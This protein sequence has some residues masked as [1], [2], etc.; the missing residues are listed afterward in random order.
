MTHNRVKDFDNHIDD[1]YD[2]LIIGIVRQAVKDLNSK[3]P[4][5]RESAALFFRDNPLGLSDGFI[6]TIRRYLGGKL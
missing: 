2:L 4:K 5:V 3:N 1:P 6:D